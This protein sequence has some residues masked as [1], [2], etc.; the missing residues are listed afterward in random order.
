MDKAYL[1]RVAQDLSQ[2]T[3]SLIL[4]NQTVQLRTTKQDGNKVVVITE[5]VSGITKVSSLKLLDEAGNL[6]TE[7]TA[8][9]D[10]LS[11][12]SLEFRFE[13]EVKGAKSDALQP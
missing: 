8:N 11:D 1:E 9:V 4:N 6:I 3:S 13:F 2:R 12:Q 10:V 5:P 7:R